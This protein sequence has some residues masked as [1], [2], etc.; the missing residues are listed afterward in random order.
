MTI[1]DVK[2]DPQ[3]SETRGSVPPV[4]RRSR[5]RKVPPSFSYRVRCAVKAYQNPPNVLRSTDVSRNRSRFSRSVKAVR[6][7]KPPRNISAKMILLCV[8]FFLIGCIV[9]N[10]PKHATAFAHSSLWRHSVHLTGHNFLV[11]DDGGMTTDQNFDLALHNQT[12]VLLD[13]SQDGYPTPFRF[14]VT[15]DTKDII[16][17]KCG[18][19]ILATQVNPV[20]NKSILVTVTF[21][22]TVTPPQ[23]RTFRVSD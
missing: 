11:Y 21:I 16:A 18:N 12:S 5:G 15:G 14:S 13:V 17:T 7:T 19:G 3:E 9:S 1:Q 22:S 6:S 2:F 23:T 4:S 20:S 10:L 8:A